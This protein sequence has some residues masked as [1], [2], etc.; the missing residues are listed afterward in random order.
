MEKIEFRV[1]TMSSCLIGNQTESFSIGGVDQSTTVDE[2]G[3]P[4][5]HGSAIKGS[6][7]NIVREHDETMCC[8][9][10]LMKELLEETK[11]KYNALEKEIKREK[12]IQNTIKKL[13]DCIQETKAEYIFGIEGINGLP[14][15]FFSDLRIEG[16]PDK[17]SCFSIET[18]T[19]LEESKNEVVSRPRTYKV[20]RAG[21]SFRGSLLFQGFKGKDLKDVIEELTKK[22]KL[23]NEG[24]YGLGNS[25]SRGYGSIKVEVFPQ[26]KE[27]V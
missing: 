17:E 24:Y 18:K 20:I 12:S 13:S 10:Q 19:S 1:T 22:L 2:E 16:R 27:N 7:R 4:I 23:F 14:R 9:K 6:L 15:L 5:I 11:E 25:K 26:Q 21:I 8:T 3:Y